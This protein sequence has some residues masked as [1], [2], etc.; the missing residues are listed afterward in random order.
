L[1]RHDE[2][3]RFEDHKARGFALVSS[4]G[5]RCHHD[6][7][8]NLLEKILVMIIPNPLLICRSFRLNM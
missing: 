4:C 6:I 1:T 7:V 8:L 2:A 3:T 5:M